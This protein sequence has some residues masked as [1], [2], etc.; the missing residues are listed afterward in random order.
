MGRWGADLSLTFAM[1]LLSC[2]QIRE[3]DWDDYPRGVGVLLDGLSSWNYDRDPLSALEF[4]GAFQ[5][6]KDIVADT[7]SDFFVHMVSR[8]LQ[9]NH[10]V[11]VELSP[12]TSLAQRH[13]EV[14]RII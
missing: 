11:I 14:S 7:G 13:E 3:L 4:E 8:L 5:E 2:N 10:R 9:N 1:L 6:L 12:D